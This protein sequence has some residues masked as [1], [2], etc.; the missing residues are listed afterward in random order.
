VHFG[1][2]SQYPA[3]ARPDRANHCD[4]DHSDAFGASLHSG[5]K[6]ATAAELMHI[7]IEISFGISADLQ[8]ST[9]HDLQRDIRRE[10]RRAL[11]GA[12]RRAIGEIERTLL[13]KPVVCPRCERPMRSRGKSPRRVV[14]I[15]GTLDLQRVR[16]GCHRC[17][18]ARRPLDE[19]LGS[20]GDTECTAAVREQA[21]YLA[22]DL[23]YERAADVLRHVGGIGISGRQIQRLVRAES[24]YIEAALGKP[25][26]EREDVLRLRFRHA[27]RGR[28]TAGAQR[29]LR[30]RQLKTSGLW[31]EY[32]GRRFREE[33]AAAPRPRRSGARGDR[34][35]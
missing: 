8:K 2:L 27:G 23:P 14:T 4:F 7:P 33:P 32:W 17:G 6:F 24:A 16:Y 9:L 22:A 20:L 15:F 35:R 12:L 10:A 3:A 18:A 26:R 11:L 28:P 34:A 13:A 5:M 21:L 25:P 30:L 19:W 1:A 29:V 31:E